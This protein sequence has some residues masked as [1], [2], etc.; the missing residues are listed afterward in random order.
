MTSEEADEVQAVFSNP[1]SIFSA[2]S[3]QEP[4]TKALTRV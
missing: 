3:G 1:Y 4:K 2:I